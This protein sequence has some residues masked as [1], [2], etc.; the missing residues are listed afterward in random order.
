MYIMA[1]RELIREQKANSKNVA[2]AV[3]VKA[4]PPRKSYNGRVFKK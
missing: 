3:K 4:P 2:N 1:L